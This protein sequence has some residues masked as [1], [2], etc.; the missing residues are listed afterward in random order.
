ML[1][2]CQPRLVPVLAGIAGCWVLV[3]GVRGPRIP[4]LG[5]ARLRLLVHTLHRGQWEEETIQSG[6]TQQI[7]HTQEQQLQKAETEK[8]KNQL[9]HKRS[10]L[11][12]LMIP[13]SIRFVYAFMAFVSPN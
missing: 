9:R 2:E 6:Q 10:Q 7:S 1:T 8:Q 5:K 13:V 11:T 12:T 3:T 4:L